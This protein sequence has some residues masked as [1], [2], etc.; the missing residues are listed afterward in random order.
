MTKLEMA[1]FQPVNPTFRV[2]ENVKTYNR[3]DY[4]QVWYLEGTDML[5]DLSDESWAEKVFE[6]SNTGK[7]Q[8]WNGHSMSVGD[9]FR[10][11]DRAYICC[12]AGWMPVELKWED[13]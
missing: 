8:D 2:D 1:V 6:L 5:S 12:N 7:I 13:K 11:N 9:I 3:A 4:R 10:I